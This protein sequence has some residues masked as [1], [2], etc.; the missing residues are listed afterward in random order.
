MPRGQNRGRLA[1]CPTSHSVLLTFRNRN[2]LE[3]AQ[4]EP[5]LTLMAVARNLERVADHATNIAEDVIYM[6]RGK[7]IRHGEFE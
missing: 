3:P 1:T 2:S 7:I 6:I 4:A 5:L